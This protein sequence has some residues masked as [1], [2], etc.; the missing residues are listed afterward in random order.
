MVNMSSNLP[1]ASFKEIYERN[2][3][4]VYRI[5]FMYLKNKADTEDAVHSTF[6]KLLET[7]KT[8]QNA[9]HEKAWLIRVSSNVCK[10]MIS[11][12]SRKVSLIEE[13]ENISVSDYHDETLMAI[14]NLPDNLKTVVYL[15]YYEGYDSIQIGKMLNITSSAVRNRLKRA[16]EKL[17]SI[18]TDEEGNK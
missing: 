4:M 13:N 18:L 14:C 5:C 7:K 8:F 1:S 6:L 12:W 2:F 9:E 11:H 17:R 3:D 10:N 15:Y 16:K